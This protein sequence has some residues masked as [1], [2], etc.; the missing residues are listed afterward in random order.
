LILPLFL[1]LRRRT[2]RAVHRLL[3]VWGLLLRLLPP[4]LIFCHLFI[5]FIQDELVLARLIPLVPNIILPLAVIHPGL[6]LS[7]N[8]QLHGLRYLLLKLIIV[9]CGRS[10]KQKCF[11][12]LKKCLVIPRSLQL[13]GTSM[14]L[15]PS[16]L[17]PTT[18]L[19]STTTMLKFKLCWMIGR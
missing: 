6:K 14:R 9:N 11:H 3:L 1:I 8:V 2:V 17:I 5:P 19:P 18:V 10:V 7:Q 13:R 16:H 4:H 12:H 15:V